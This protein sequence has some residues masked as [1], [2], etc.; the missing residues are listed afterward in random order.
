MTPD[1]RVM[2]VVHR[3]E[4]RRSRHPGTALPDRDALVQLLEPTVS[5]DAIDAALDRLTR[6]GTLRP[7]HGGWTIAPDASDRARQLVDRLMGEAFGEWMVAAEASPAFR[8]LCAR[9]NRLPFVVFDMLDPEQL[10]AALEAAALRPG[11]R[12]LDLGCG[13]GT[14]TEEV[15]RRT[16]AA[17]HGVDLAPAAIHRA[18]ERT[19]G[20]DGLRFE[21][22][23]LDVVD[24]PPESWDAIFAFDTLSFADDLPRLI[25]ACARGLRPGGRLVATWSTLDV[26]APERDPDGTRLARALRAAGLG[27]TTTEHTDAELAH[28]RRSAEAVAALEAVFAAEGSRRWWEGRRRE[29]EGVL[30][31]C[32][33]GRN[34][35]F[36]YRA[37]RGAGGKADGT[38]V[39]G[40]RDEAPRMASPTAVRAQPPTDG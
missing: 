22:L 25:A 3:A 26:P 29:T 28:W 20:D 19:A 16:G 39:D 32:E 14:L 1:E 21:V 12:A 6:D 35:R 40:P 27:Y 11:Q 9:V 30:P 34:R 2:A 24:P 33:Q 38:D 7:D 31:L 4:R 10:D 5:P 8:E 23:A 17:L 36:L 37:T 18:A 15:R 13:I